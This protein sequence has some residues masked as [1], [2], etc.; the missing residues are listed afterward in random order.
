M[1]IRVNKVLGYGLTD[2]SYDTEKWEFDDPRI[3][4]ESPLLTYDYSVDHNDE[5]RAWVKENSTDSFTESWWWAD[6]DKDRKRRY[7]DREDVRDCVV[8]QSEYGLPNVLLIRPF[9][10]TDWHRRD[11]SIDYI[12]ASANYAN[13]DCDHVRDP[14]YPFSGYMDTRTGERIKADIM[15]WVRAK[16]DNREDSLDRL[17]QLGGFADHADALAHCAPHV[18]EPIQNIARYG[19]LFTSDDVFWQLR[20]ILYTYWS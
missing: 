2:V 16:N 18:P 10:Y 6:K 14:I 17:A 12:E 7:A 11:D 8:H 4:G 1:G 13:G 15:P 3:N 19:K 9:G 20:P 5:Y